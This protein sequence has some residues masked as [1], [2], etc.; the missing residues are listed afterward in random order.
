MSDLRALFNSNGPA[1]RPRIA[2]LWQEA[3]KAVL[4]MLLQEHPD[5]LVDVLTSD[6]QLARRLVQ[7]S[8]RKLR[9]LPSLA[10]C[11][12]IEILQLPPRKLGDKTTP[13]HSNHYSLRAADL[14]YQLRAVLNDLFY[15]AMSGTP[16][17]ALGARAPHR[18]FG[19]AQKMPGG[20]VNVRV[21]LIKKERDLTVELW[22]AQWLKTL[23]DYGKTYDLP[24][25]EEAGSKWDDVSI[26]DKFSHLQLHTLE[27]DAYDYWVNEN[28]DRMEK[29]FAEVFHSFFG[30]KE[31]WAER[32]AK[33]TGGE[34][35][36]QRPRLRIVVT[37]SMKSSFPLPQD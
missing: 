19:V 9:H 27:H 7:E 4:P 22:A 8:S 18:H 21:D 15:H 26:R 12:T 16:W 10:D 17:L 33:S 24:D 2:P 31:P 28:D 32:M 14:P 36:T 30:A 3:L 35:W 23:Y 5:A 11:D 29:E 25:N 20:T 37:G 6:V 34:V 13:Y 1:K